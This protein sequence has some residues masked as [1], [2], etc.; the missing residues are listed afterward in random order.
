MVPQ[1]YTRKSKFTSKQSHNMILS[2]TDALRIGTD[3]APENAPLSRSGD[4]VL[5]N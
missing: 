3:A 5:C 4:G 2:N 1:S